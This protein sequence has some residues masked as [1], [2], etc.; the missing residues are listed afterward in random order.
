MSFKAEEVTHYKKKKTINY[1]NASFR[2]YDVPVL[3]FPKFFHPDPTVDRQSGFLAPSLLAQ[4]K[5]IYLKT[6]YFHVLS[7]SSDFTFSPR[8]YDNQ[9]NIYQGEYRK[10]TKNSKH[11][12]DASIKNKNTFIYGKNA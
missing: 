8:L 10:V 5:G 9:E 11:T 3:Y 2:F 7:N 12:F 1:K 6:P 4:K